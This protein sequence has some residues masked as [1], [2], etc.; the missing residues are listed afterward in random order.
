[1]PHP[2]MPAAVRIEQ[3]CPFSQRLL[4]PMARPCSNCMSWRTVRGMESDIAVCSPGSFGQ[5]QTFADRRMIIE[6]PG[7]QRVRVRIGF[8]EFRELDECGTVG[9]R[10]R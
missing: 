8:V 6:E 7:D 4:M 2:T 3:Y 9:R 5:C 1:M 10:I